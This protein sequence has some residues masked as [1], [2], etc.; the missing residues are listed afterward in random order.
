MTRQ[1][2]AAAFQFQPFSK[3]QKQVLTWWHPD[4]PVHD[5][6][7]M[8]ADGAVRSGKTVPT[9]I[10]FVV[11]SQT[12]FQ[13]QA[14]IIA[15]RSMG[16]VKRNILR[17][18]FSILAAMGIPYRYNQSEHYVQIGTNTY[19][20]FGANNEVA[21]DVVLGL[22]AAGALL[23]EVAL[24]PESFVEQAIAR[25]SV[26]GA[27]IF[28]TCNPAG[29]P[30]HWFKREYIDK[31]RE[32]RIVYLHFTMDDNLTLSPE[33][34]ARYQR[35]F[36][37]LWYKRYILGL[38]VLAEG[39][40]YDMFDEAVHV[41]D[42]MPDLPVRAWLVPVDYGTANPTGFLKIA[43][44]RN[45]QTKQEEAYVAGEYYWD[46]RQ[47]GR[48]KTDAEYSA[49][50]REFIQGLNRTAPVT[51]YVDPSAAS[52]K[53]QLKKDGV[54]NV[55]DADNA[56]LD[57]IRLVASFFSTRRLFIVRGAA[58]NLLRELASYVWDPKAQARGENAPLKENDHLAD[59]LRYG[60]YTYFK[61]DGLA[62]APVA[63]HPAW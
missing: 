48:Q 33:R 51:I 35:M 30:Q 34:K 41:V 15:G 21:Q 29:G 53:A 1:A 2:T 38:W 40:V 11:W 62:R 16:A 61:R 10:S 4:S 47:K 56:I 59:A 9:I 14:F 6:D 24:F 19:Y 43:V 13:H 26:E 44:V 52:F 37:G 55:K 23:D 5:Y 46:S 39:A 7:M 50:L 32:K 17:P 8:I 54:H 20:L 25:C 31:A 22:T 58:P 63:K 27:K 45:Q 57:G 18:M 3:K 42:R 49:D 28:C 60:L 12:T 36:S